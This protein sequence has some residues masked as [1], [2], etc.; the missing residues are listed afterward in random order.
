MSLGPLLLPGEPLPDARKPCALGAN[1]LINFLILFIK[2]QS[3]LPLL[4]RLVPRNQCAP[5]AHNVTSLR[6]IPSFKLVCS[7]L[8]LDCNYHVS[9]FKQAV[10]MDEKGIT[11]LGSGPYAALWRGD[12]RSQ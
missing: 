8:D 3:S 11:K 4:S 2:V 12:N 1:A 5:Y 9:R 10:P 7:V 6:Q